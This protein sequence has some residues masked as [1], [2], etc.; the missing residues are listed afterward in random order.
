M[1]VHKTWDDVRV[2][3]FW[4]QS[5]GFHN[6][7]NKNWCEILLVAILIPLYLC[8]VL[9]N[10]TWD[11]FSSMHVLVVLIP[12]SLSIHALACEL[13]V[14]FIF[15]Y[16]CIGCVTTWE[17]QCKKKD[18]LHMHMWTLWRFCSFLDFVAPQ[19]NFAYCFIV[20]RSILIIFLDIKY[21]HFSSQRDWGHLTFLLRTLLHHGRPWSGL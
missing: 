12:M 15:L 10:H 17:S 1:R 5:L 16:A 14:R 18:T 13:Y 7:L 20:S 6:F 8:V 11:S 3:R 4:F 21:G 9:L 2:A 19:V